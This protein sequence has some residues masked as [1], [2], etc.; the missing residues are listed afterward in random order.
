MQFKHDLVDKTDAFVKKAFQDNPHYSFNHWS[1]MYNH[2]VNVQNLSMK[3]ANDIKCNELV[4]SI[5]ALLHDIGKIYHADQ[6]TLH[7]T[8]ESFNLIV[9][10]DFLDNL[11]LTS[12]ELKQVRDLISYNSDS[13]EMKIIKDADAL[14]MCFDKKLY[15]LWIEW[16]IKNGFTSD[17][18]RKLN[19]YNNLYFDISRRLAEPNLI[20]M[21]NDWDK[22]QQKIKKT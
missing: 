5:A 22:Y 9:T 13:T 18:Q 4:T 19:K 6:K 12:T 11:G 15:M 14:A 3:I 8:H 1:V 21:K 7:K 16:A 20:K 2:S 17:I 10:K